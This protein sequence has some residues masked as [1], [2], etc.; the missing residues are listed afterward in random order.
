MRRFFIIL[1]CVIGCL[2][3]MLPSF[4]LVVVD[5]RISEPVEA[6]NI[7]YFVLYN[8]DGTIGRLYQ[9]IAYGF[10]VQYDTFYVTFYAEPNGNWSYLGN[11]TKYNPSS[12][13]S[14]SQS[15]MIIQYDLVDGHFY[16]SY[17]RNSNNIYSTSF[18][19]SN[20][21]YYLSYG[22]EYAPNYTGN[23]Q[24]KMPQLG[25]VMWNDDTDYTTDFQAINTLLS[26]LYNRLDLTY[27]DIDAI[28]LNLNNFFSWFK[29][30]YYSTI[31]GKWD[32]TNNN[33]NTIISYLRQLIDGSNNPTLPNQDSFNNGVDGYISSESGYIDN[34]NN[35][36]NDIG[37]QF[38]FASEKIGS[39][40]STFAFINNVFN[41]FI[42]SSSMPY[43]I[44]FISLSFG[45]IVL[46][47]GRKVK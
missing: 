6:P 29:S 10:D 13:T 9:F 25:S 41:T 8:A 38:D 28:L 7:K 16:Y 35:S 5:S 46:L 40:S 17:N 33:L 3:F 36:I 44:I 15:Y 42:P 2:A 45:L 23:V 21:K 24:N 19:I 4:A 1:I 20:Y 32:L 39:F 30:T 34:F 12:N 18:A 43:V 26:A 14:S 37:S 11:Y 47:L 22:C 27:Q 31:T